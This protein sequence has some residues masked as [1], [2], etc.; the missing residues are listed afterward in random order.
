[1]KIIVTIL[2][3]YI[4]YKVVFDFV[5]PVAK[6]TSQFK[7]QVSQM[8]RM[9]EEQLRKQQQPPKSSSQANKTSLSKNTT[10]TDGEYIDFEDVK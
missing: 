3:L 2:I 1:M 4:I 9:Q 6:T 10:I 8:Q 7:K 5:V